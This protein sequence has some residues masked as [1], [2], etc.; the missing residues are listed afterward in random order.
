[1]GF[2]LKVLDMSCTQFQVERIEHEVVHVVT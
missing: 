2:K 1:M